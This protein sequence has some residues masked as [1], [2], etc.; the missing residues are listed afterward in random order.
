[1]SSP[2]LTYPSGSPLEG[3]KIIAQ[4]TVLWV[5]PSGNDG[6]GDGTTAAPYQT[7]SRAMNVA[8]EH[9][10]TGRAT[11]TVRLTEGEHI[12]TDP[13]DLYHPQGTNLIIEGDPS[14]V[15]QRTLWRVQGYRWSPLAFAGGG[16]TAHISLFNSGALVDAENHGLTASHAGQYFALTNAACGARSGYRTAGAVQDSAMGIHAPP[17]SSYD[18]L[19]WGDRFFSHGYSYEDGNGIL[20]LGRIASLE[21]DETLGVEFH[22]LNYDGRCPAWQMDG[23]IGNSITWGGLT[24]NYPETQ[25]SQPDGYY[26][27]SQWTTED[28]SDT[29]PVKP[30]GT[31]HI[32][33]DPFVLTTFPVRIRAQWS[34][35]TSSLYLKGGTLRALRNLCLVSADPPYT[36]GT[37]AS[38]SAAIT[39]ISRQNRW[40][41]ANGTA[42]ALENATVGIRH[43]GVMGAGTAISAVN[44]RVLKYSDDT[45]DT[46][47]TMSTTETAR[48]GIVGSLDNAPILV[49]A[50]CQNGIVA[51]GSTVDFTDG[52]GTSSEYRKDYRDSSVHI[53]ARSKGIALFGSTFRA[54]TVNIDLSALVPN[55]KFDALVPVF[56]GFT[57]EGNTGAF[58]RSA[59]SSQF[60]YDYPLGRAT[61]T[62]SSGVTHEIGHLN[63]MERSGDQGVTGVNGLT[64]GVSYGDSI[65]PAYWEKYTFYGLKTSA[66]SLPLVSADD[67]RHGIATQSGVPL[68][69]GTLDVE[70]FGTADGS[71][72][73]SSLRIGRNAITASN[74]GGS[75]FGVLGI[76]GSTLGAH[77][78][79]S[80]SSYGTPDTYMG[81]IHDDRTSAFQAYDGSSAVV[82]KGMNIHNGGVVA[83]EIAKSS[84][85]VVGDSLVNGN[86]FVTM[87]GSGETETLFGNFNYTTGAVC[88]TGYASAGVYC[89]DDS[90]F[91]IGTL[92]TKHPT[93]LNCFMDG[94][95][96]T[97]HAKP[98]RLDQ[99][100]RG[101]VGGMFC[102]LTPGLGAVLPVSASQTAATVGIGLWKSLTGVG[103]GVIPFDP[104][105]LNGFVSV[106]RHSS[107]VLELEAGKKIF[108]FD[109]GNPN[110]TGLGN[111]RNT[112]LVSAKHASYV[113]FA[114]CQDSSA[115]P[116][117][118]ANEANVKTK[119]STDERA[120]ADQRIATRSSGANATLYNTNG[121][122]RPW[123]GDMDMMM[124]SNVMIHDVNIGNYGFMV[125]QSGGIGQKD[126]LPPA[127]VTYCTSFNG[128]SKIIGI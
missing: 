15:A 111:P 118:H 32:S 26:G 89:W 86:P 23:G 102:V 69:G 87:E 41:Q 99:L 92:F 25:Y 40:V 3:V 9:T 117:E 85:L 37:T 63:W 64:V 51:K 62:L 70:F 110:W 73:R 2:H 61:L 11:L 6:N 36:A 96:N 114:N 29:Y 100:C 27:D 39:A 81:N 42:V 76:T 75:T 21:D 59:S 14:A 44:S 7:L 74:D 24:D 109:G 65:A 124:S 4:D 113:L 83:V 71:V 60:L 104:S 47:N 121:S 58:I 72:V 46:T 80:F 57:A 18:P 12:L 88:I 94:D 123:Y 68:R 35:N 50:H 20:G 52:S 30:G 108:H 49:T 16:H 98:V 55:F 112:S 105:R 106:E 67:V 95:G 34:S 126:I 127:G 38:P 128:F 122:I 120:E 28:G 82:E 54:T 97:S 77:V 78:L 22:N 19:F 101:I 84:A 115:E 5:S 66:M 43:I 31:R 8:R 79:Q 17:A 13:V 10:I 116:H 53:G 48:G 56:P 103:Y 107:L 90:R 45:I 91:M 1:M 93:P 33:P 125:A 119:F